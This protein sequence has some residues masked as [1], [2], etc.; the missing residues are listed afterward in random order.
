MTRKILFA[1]RNLLLFALMLT[2]IAMACQLV[3]PDSQPDTEQILP[4]TT[5]QEKIT[6]IL[7][8]T[9]AS[10]AELTGPALSPTTYQEIEGLAD[11]SSQGSGFVYDTDG[12]IITNAHVVHGSDQI[13]V[14]FAD[15]T[16]LSAERIGEDLHSD[17]AV[18]KT[19]KL[20]EGVLPA[21][22][23]NDND[24]VVGQTV[25]AI[26]N[27]FGLGGTLTRGI[28][29][30]LGRTIPALTSFSI[31]KAIQT[32]AAIN[33]GNSGG[34]LLNLNGEVIG[35][36]AQIQTDGFTRSNQGVGFAIPV[37]I[38]KRVVP[39]LI[40]HGEFDWSWLGVVG[41]DVTPEIALAMELPVQKGAYLS[42]IVSDGPAARANLQ[43][44]SGEET[45][46]GRQTPV[47]GDV[48]IAI[49]GQPV[50]SFDDLLVYIALETTPGQ[51]VTLTILRDGEQQ[52]IK[53][54][55]G[56]RPEFI[57]NLLHP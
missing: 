19:E 41:G 42:R 49:D 33:P 48:I 43:G 26:G 54:T 16:I 18:L 3:T 34:P 21:Q 5:I 27:P 56:Y 6:P 22:L 11:A 38:V 9:P 35:V 31:P 17:L 12:H 32:D 53:L 15:G 37:S 8:S 47:G 13:D 30:A 1:N 24:L 57:E 46:H 55:M 2:L 7:A 10:E 23:G 20:P 51:E 39:D 29:S 45:I 28:V 44:D 40:Q 36:N 25:I 52:I 4:S 14:A 50:Q